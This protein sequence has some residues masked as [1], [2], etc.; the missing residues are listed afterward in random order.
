MAFTASAG[1]VVVIP[2]K[3]TVSEAQFFF[4][5]RNLKQAEKEKAEAVILDMDTYGGDLKAAVDM[6][7]ALFNTSVPVYTYINANAGSAGALIAVST[8]RI[9]MAPVS[10]VGAAAPVLGNGQDLQETMS[11]KIVSYY[12]AY[13]RSAAERNGH[14]PDIAE[15]FINKNKEVIVGGTT[16]HSKGSVLT[17]S[18]QEAAKI[19]GDK[20]LFSAGIADNLQDLVTK[21]GLQ[22]SIRRVE[23]TGF[24]RMAFFITMLAP[25]LLL[26]GIIGAYIEFKTPGF[27][28]PGICS[29][30]CF[31]LFF[32][33]HY[34]AGLAGMEVFVIFILG[35]VLVVSELVLHPGTILPGLLGAM[36]VFGAVVYAMIDHYPTQPVLPSPSMLYVPAINLLISGF[37]AAVTIGILARYLPQTSFYRRVV[38]NAVNPV[39]PS[40]QETSPVA[41]LKAGMEGQALSILRPSGR[42]QFGDI[43][44]DVIT[45]GEFLSP[46][47]PIRIMTVEGARVIVEKADQ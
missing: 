20:P 45:E 22:G 14:N 29:I 37:L 1:D 23:P 43:V 34:I 31:A 41:V 6:Q 32:T 18:A 16:I 11:D 10:A 2:M 30:I 7:G 36:M 46:G 25:L 3:G 9:Y 17:F 19:V 47:T 42:A 4:L 26:G 12:S 38:L 33:G 8:K 13:F 15:A 39:G 24:E 35:I 28:I 27:G 44:I 40:I 21:A 5:R